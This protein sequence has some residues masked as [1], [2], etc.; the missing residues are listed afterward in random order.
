MVASV[1]LPPDV[2][3]RLRFLQRDAEVAAAEAEVTALRAKALASERFAAFRAALAEAGAS[4]G[5]DPSACDYAWH[6]GACALVA[7]EQPTPVMGEDHRPPIGGGV[8]TR[9]DA[10][11][12]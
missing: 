8:A 11:K 4:H 7:P 9:T 6:D 10:A 2:Y 12:E 1:V 3:Y 5:F